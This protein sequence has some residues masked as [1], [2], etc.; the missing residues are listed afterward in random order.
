MRFYAVKY[1][2]FWCLF[3]VI[4]GFEFEVSGF[5]VFVLMSLFVVYYLWFI[6]PAAGLAALSADCMGDLFVVYY[7]IFM[8]YCSCGRVALSAVSGGY[9]LL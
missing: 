8:V 7:L 9:D 2:G 5:E 1:R 3:Y 4:S 6:V